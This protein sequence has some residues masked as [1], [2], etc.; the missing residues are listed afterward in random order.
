MAP[1]DRL[2]S[3]DRRIIYTVIGLSVLF[4]ILVPLGLPVTVTPSTRLS[5]DAIEALPPG[6]RVLVSFDYGPSTAPENDPMAAAVLRHCFKRDLRV[7]SIALYPLGGDAVDRQEMDLVAREFPEK[8]DT[9]DFVNLGYKDG[10]Q[11]PMKKMG[12]DIPGTYPTDAAGRPYKDLPILQ[13]VTGY[14]DFKLGVTFA[15]GI[16]GEWWANLVNAQFKLP[17]VIGPTAVSAPKYFAYLN[18]GNAVGLIGGLK[19]ASEYEKL[20]VDKYPDLAP[21]YKK[22]GVYTATK[23][24]EAQNMAHVLIVGFILFGNAIFLIEKRRRS[25]AGGAA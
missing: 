11:A 7:V 16:I 1:L 6:S 8:K 12:D 10:G 9:I 15:T 22:P 25:A 24:M 5:F 21:L 23:G 4:P 13:G 19:G 17:I 18:S 3:L 20:L 2:A 14:R